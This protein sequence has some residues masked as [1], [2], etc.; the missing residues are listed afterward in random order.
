[1]NR[2][3]RFV[4]QINTTNESFLKLSIKLKD[5][6]VKNNMFFLKLYD[7]S[8][9]YVNPFDDNLSIETKQKI[10]QE[11]IINPWYYLREC[12]AIPEQG[13][14]GGTP[15]VLH[16]ANLASIYC[17]LNGIDHYS[18]YPYQTYRRASYN[19]LL[20]WLFM[21]G[22]TT[23][24]FRYMAS[25]FSGFYNNMSRT[26]SQVA[27]LPDY[28][29]T[30]MNMV[31]HKRTT[32]ENFLSRNVIRQIENPKDRET[33]EQMGNEAVG[34]IQYFD[35]FE[36]IPF[37]G[38]IIESSAPAMYKMRNEKTSG[39]KPCRIFTTTLGDPETNE[40]AAFGF[41]MQE[42]GLCWKP[43]MFDLTIDQLREQIKINSANDIV[44]IK[45]PYKEMGLD[46]AWFMNACRMCFNDAQRIRREVHLEYY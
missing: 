8:L 45:V 35:D 41:R 28:L 40:S 24:E 16:L 12:V 13:G 7:P 26:L 34:T 17:T 39:I 32:M 21:F 6:G 33:A 2:T 5:M 46:D 44:I 25:S 10:I 37:V 9:Q 15:F 14:E 29:S 38:E 11:I 43:E 36:H 22:G 3:K 4:Y 30:I 23:T 20:H 31:V 1:L 27:I 19:T 42:Q 18:V